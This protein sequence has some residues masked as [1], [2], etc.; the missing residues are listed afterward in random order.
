MSFLILVP[1]DSRAM[2]T[3]EELS[4]AGVE[5]RLDR[6]E[7]AGDDIVTG[8]DCVVVVVEICYSL[9]IMR[10][11]MIRIK[12]AIDREVVVKWC[13]RDAGQNDALN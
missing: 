4:S 1:G 8:A 6:V 2:D 3:I 10:R 11:R 5:A 12:A 9:M 13:G 7:R